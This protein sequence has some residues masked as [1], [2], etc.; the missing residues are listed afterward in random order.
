MMRFAFTM[1]FLNPL[2]AQAVTL[3]PVPTAPIYYEPFVIE[4]DAATQT[5]SCAQLDHAI[6][7]LHPYRYTHK[8][9]F[10]QDGFNQKAT[11][12][13]AF[14][15]IPVVEGWLGLG[16]LGY[17]ALVGEKESRRQLIVEHQI[18][19]LQH[20]KAQQHCYE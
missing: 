18:A 13:I 7:A 8:P 1:L 11:A 12:L 9:D 16:L 6:N 17:S 5:L 10:Y 3:P 19:S 14:D 20:V 4:A 15:V 2:A